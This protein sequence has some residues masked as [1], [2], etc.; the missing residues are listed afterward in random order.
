MI[1]SIVTV[2][3][4]GQL[5][6]MCCMNLTQ[7]VSSMSSLKLGV[8]YYYCDFNLI[9]CSFTVS[10]VYHVMGSGVN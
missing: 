8:F 2:L 1:D 6:P 9:A 5:F 3:S 10:D 7:A 4:Y